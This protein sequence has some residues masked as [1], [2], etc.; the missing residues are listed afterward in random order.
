[1]TSSLKSGEKIV[2]Y[3]GDCPM[4][5]GTVAWLLRTGLLKSEQAR[6]N[7]DLA[8]A[9]L[10]AAKAAG[11][12]NQLVVLDP[13]T[14]ETRSGAEGLLWIIRDNTGNH[15]L[16][17]LLSLP[18]FRHALRWGYETIS[19]NRRVISPPR[20]QIVC[21]CEP[22]VTLA[23]R[24]ML[25]VPALALTVLLTALFGAAVFHGWQLGD[26][27]SGA[28]FMVAAAGSIWIALAI[29][30]IVLLRGERRVD[31][32]AHLAVTMLAGALVLVPASLVVPL[33]PRQGL[34]ALDGVSALA[35]FWLM[36]LMQRRR[37]AAVGLSHRWLWAWV[38]ALAVGFAATKYLYFWVLA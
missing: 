30:A 28:V 16:V 18:G 17:R 35:S 7:H 24:L 20:H 31:Y 25:I 32:L 4:C 19:Y 15:F 33:L 5:T 11:I 27:W 6:S 34:I 13:E 9:D 38:A 14:R 29:V 12:R 2:V 10:D 1:M 36:F 22:E 8:G 23:R 21:D 3:D 37:V 26:G